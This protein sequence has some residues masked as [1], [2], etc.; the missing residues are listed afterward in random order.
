M[1][2]GRKA[3][4]CQNEVFQDGEDVRWVPIILEQNCNNILFQLFQ[5]QINIQAK[6]MEHT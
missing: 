4:K 6:F 2:F 3:E 5:N 1:T